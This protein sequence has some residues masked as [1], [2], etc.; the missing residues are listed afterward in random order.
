[1]R[2]V[3][4]LIYVLERASPAIFQLPDLYCSV[5]GFES[6]IAG[7]NIFMVFLRQ[8]SRVQAVL[9]NDTEVLEKIRYL[10]WS[11]R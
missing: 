8:L 9:C 2:G 3:I 5:R 7:V 4:K 1:M 6:L 11:F 10:N